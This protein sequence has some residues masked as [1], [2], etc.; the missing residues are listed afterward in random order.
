MLNT[1]TVVGVFANILG[2][3]FPPKWIPSFSWGGASGF[4]V[5]VQEQALLVATRVM[6]RRNLTPDAVYRA[7]LEELWRQTQW[8]RE[9]SL[10]S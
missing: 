3:G 8:E 4:E 5:F 2:T 7:F 6:Q 10:R 1:G 9:I